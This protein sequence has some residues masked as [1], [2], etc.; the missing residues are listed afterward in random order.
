MS[1]G[2]G[3]VKRWYRSLGVVD[4]TDEL[5]DGKEE[6]I[7]NSK[8]DLASAPYNLVPLVNLMEDRYDQ[9]DHLAD[10]TQQRIYD[11]IRRK[12]THINADLVRRDKIMDFETKMA[13]EREYGKEQERKNGV[14]KA[15]SISRHLGMP[16]SKILPALVDEYQKS[17]TKAELEQMMK[18]V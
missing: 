5:N 3:P 15:I 11:K 10:E 4:R 2:E 7:I 8:G 6:I 1:D 17:F 18:E 9:L 16:D 14:R 13:E 12:I